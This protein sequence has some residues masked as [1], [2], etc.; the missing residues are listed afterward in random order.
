MNSS[1]PTI[2]DTAMHRVLF[3]EMTTQQQEQ[4]LEQIRNRRL[5]ALQTRNELE[6]KKQIIKDERTRDTIEKEQR[7]L[8]KEW[9]ALDKAIQKVEVRL[10]KITAYANTIGG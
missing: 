6:A 8:Q 2:N 9:D 10:L 4:M 7:M 3:V 1:A 5:V